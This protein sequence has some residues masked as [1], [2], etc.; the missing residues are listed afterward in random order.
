MLRA[1]LSSFGPIVKRLR[2]P[3]LP[4]RLKQDEHPKCPSVSKP[5]FRDVAEVGSGASMRSFSQQLA[6][7]RKGRQTE[8]HIPP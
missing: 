1:G 5:L 7:E 8:D 3:E 4:I 2:A 6:D